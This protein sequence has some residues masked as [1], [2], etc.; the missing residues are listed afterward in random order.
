MVK[1][2]FIM[3]ANFIYLFFKLLPSKDKVA[4]I[5]RQSDEITLDFKLLKDEI[6]K[7]Y[8]NISVITLCHKL[9]GGE[10]ASILEK[11]KYIIHCFKQMYHIATSKVVVLDSY[12]ILVSILKHK[13]NLKIIQMW[14]SMGTMKQFGYQILDLEEGRSSK[15]AKTMRMHKNYD[16]IFASSKAYAGCLAEGFDYDIEKVEIYSLPRVDLL[17]SDKYKKEVCSKIDKVYPQVIRK[18]NIVYC[19]TFRKDEKKML[20]EISKLIE[21]VDYSKYNL[22]LKL[23]PLSKI[24]I[25]NEN[26]ICD[27]TFSSFDMLFIADYVI[28]DYS[29]I[30]YEAAI[31]K[32]PLYFWAFDLKKYLNN[33]GLTLDYKKEVPGL[34][35]DNI[36]D[37]LRG[38]EEENYD[39]IKLENFRNKY[40]VNIDKCTKKIANFIVD[41]IKNRYKNGETTKQSETESFE[42]LQTHV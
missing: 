19:P 37:I 28:S 8:K 2:I 23:H 6:E 16:Y 36:Q 39:S 7:E 15:T 21:S 9:E 29:C 1:Q 11:A 34:V 17:T 20:K 14:H 24:K 41:I 25:D 3:C 35:S 22:I 4:M 18:K 42:T 40:V 32:I 12:C 5:S 30:I 27:K 13:K 33:R 38:I 26:V 31:L 10:K